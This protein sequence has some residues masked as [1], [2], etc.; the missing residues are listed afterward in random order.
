[1]A[2]FTDSNLPQFNPYVAQL[3]VDAM[4]K[5]GMYKQEKY[6]QGVTKIQNQIDQVAGLDIMKNDHKNYLQSKLNELG[7]DL[8]GVA[9]A[10]FSD[11]QL[12]NSVSGMTKQIARDPVIQNAV[13]STAKVRKEMSNMDVA[14][15]AGKSG[16]SNE[17]Y[18]NKGVSSW[19]DDGNLNSSY[20]GEFTNKVDYDKMVMDAIHEAHADGLA[21]DENVISYDKSGKPF[22][23]PEILDHK[24]KEGLSSSKVMGIVRSVYEK[25]EVQQQLTM[26][27]LYHYKDYTPSQLVESKRASLDYQKAQIY[28]ANPAL[29]AYSVLG[30]SKR[31]ALANKDLEYNYQKLASLDREFYDFTQSV[32]SNFDAAKINS[33]TDDKVIE[34]GNNYSW[35]KTSSELKVNPQFTVNMQKSEFALNQQK[36]KEQLN[37]DSW[38]IENIKSEINS[39]NLHDMIDQMKAEGKLDANGEKIWQV[40]GPEDVA[41]DVDYNKA[42][43]DK[44]LSDLNSQKNNLFANITSGIG[45]SL[46]GK[47]YRDLYTRDANNNFVINPK[48]QNPNTG[49]LSDLGQKLIDASNQQLATKIDAAGNLHLSGS[50]DKV[51]QDQIKQWWDLNTLYNKKKEAAAE[52]E[53]RH[54]GATEYD[55]KMKAQNAE[56][57]HQNKIGVGGIAQ[58]ATQLTQWIGNQFSPDLSGAVA[59]RNAE[60]ADLQRQNKMNTVLFN[61]S[62]PKAKDQMRTSLLGELETLRKDN[63][64]KGWLN[65]AVDILTKP[66]TGTD[67]LMTNNIFKFKQ[68][69]TTGKWFVNISQGSGNSFTETNHDIELSSGFAQKWNLNSQ[70]NPKESAY[71]NSVVGGIL[72]LNRGNSTASATSN[73]LNSPEAHVTALQRTPVGNYTVAWHTQ[74]KDN[75]NETFIPYLYFS[76]KKTGVAYPPVIMDW[77]KLAA[78]PGLTKTDKAILNNT[79]LVVDRYDVPNVFTQFVETI[80]KL[81]NPDAAIQLLLKDQLNN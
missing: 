10:D 61:P 44:D 63:E 72:D 66:G 57:E 80:Q 65:A 81:D 47:V 7:N 28:S 2:S 23:N 79:P 67:G 26:D 24:I 16:P 29:Q 58:R 19:L 41:T 15:K 9:A 12:V 18:F 60:Y 22:I 68:N 6:E 69:P 25:P 48:Y 54:P 75:F 37:M 51:Y 56:L 64:G 14:R 77:S 33:F 4:V 62:D 43:F 50:A 13:S 73:D 32:A 52:I 34:A 71:K 78:L 11:F 49:G 30:D 1:M 3:P 21:E 35:S 53:K 36:F 5:V 45:V 17:W 76:N 38:H 27:G 40:T 46:D 74:S 31:K 42:S 59:A 8:T 55:N 70:I 20:S 39:R